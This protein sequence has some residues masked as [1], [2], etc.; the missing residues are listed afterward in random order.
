MVG[1]VQI[2]FEKGKQER[3]SRKIIE[4]LKVVKSKCINTQR[5]RFFSFEIFLVPDTG[6]GLSFRDIIF[7]LALSP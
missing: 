7:R 5:R 1:T 6:Q 3:V 4:S 2:Y